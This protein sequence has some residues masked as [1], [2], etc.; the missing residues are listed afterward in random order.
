M[1]EPITQ[2][3]GE[4]PAVKPTL[5]AMIIERLGSI[6]GSIVYLAAITAIKWL[7][8]TVLVVALVDLA[9]QIYIITAISIFFGRLVP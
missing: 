5:N 2:V 3:T 8:V 7:I 1:D 9:L 6:E 4:L